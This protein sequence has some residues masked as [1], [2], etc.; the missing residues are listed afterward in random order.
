MKERKKERKKEL[1]HSYSLKIVN[2]NAIACQKKKKHQQN[3]LS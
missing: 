3:D 1:K 2:N